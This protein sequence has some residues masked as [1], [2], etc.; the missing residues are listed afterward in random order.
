[1]IE[2]LEAPLV[3]LVNWQ[4]GEAVAQVSQV[5]SRHI[6]F[7]A[8]RDAEIILGTDAIINWA[9]QTNGPLPVT[10][11]DFP[12][13]TQEWISA[14]PGSQ[15][16]LVAL[17]TADKHVP[18]GV[19]IVADRSDRKWTS[20]DFTLISILANQLAWSRRHL[21]LIDVLMARQESL[22]ALN[23]YKHNRLAEVYRQLESSLERLSDPLTQGKG[24]TAQ[25]QLQLVRQLKT[26]NQGVEQVLKTEAWELQSHHQTTPMI[27][28]LNRLME[29][30]NPL[31]KM[32]HL[33]AK[34]HNNSNAIIAGDLEKVELV[35]FEVMVAACERS[36][37][38]GRLD[39][40]CRPLD[41]TLI[42]IAITDDGDVPRQLLKEL[43]NGRP[44]DVLMPS[45]LDYPPGLHLNI[46]QT[47]MQQAGGEFGLQKLDDGRIMSRVVLTSA[48]KG[49]AMSAP[50]PQS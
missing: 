40:W 48:N 30:V 17:K 10:W 44:D 3:V 16:L 29:R 37:E 45:M 32:R 24:L 8:D 9:Q 25:R 35:L 41:R 4:A 39:I 19:W 50:K 6:D 23:W 5:V 47:L 22:E 42:E 7:G 43:K 28:L 46:C 38:Q 34:V 49:T 27:S 13:E 14:L 15:F 33:W 2:L 18:N 20:H 26:L 12:P 31:I 21:N 11:E 1:L 36:P